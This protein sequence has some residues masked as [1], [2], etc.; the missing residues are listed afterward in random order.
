MHQP[1]YI[2]RKNGDE[3]AETEMPPSQERPQAG[4]VRLGAR[5]DSVQDAVDHAK[6]LLEG[7]DPEQEEV[8][9]SIANEDDY[10]LAVVNN[11]RIRGT[12]YKQRWNDNDY[13]VDMGE[14]EFD[15]TNAILLMDLDEL[16]ALEDNDDSTDYIG[17][18]FIDW[19]GPHYV[20]IVMSILGYFGV[21]SLREITEEAL[22]FA[23]AFA[24]AQPAREVPIQVALQAT[25]LLQPG[26]DLEETL[27][28]LR[29]SLRSEIPGVRSDVTYAKV[30]KPAQA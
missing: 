5:F 17:K 9:F 8:V 27:E 14:E 1:Q 11:C 28:N 23:R 22:V 4:L 19:D 26:V 18:D 25:L 20:T 30:T 6:K 13:A 24:N 29:F 16:Q 3:L 7:F 2:L 15:A 21:E 10:L 12:F